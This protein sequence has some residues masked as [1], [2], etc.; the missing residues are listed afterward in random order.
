MDLFPARAEL[1]P[2]RSDLGV[3]ITGR[4]GNPVFLTGRELYNEC[5]YRIIFNYHNSPYKN[6]KFTLKVN[7]LY[8][9]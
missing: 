7:Y 8:E 5:Y 1:V 6:R 9:L 4:P 2:V 3:L